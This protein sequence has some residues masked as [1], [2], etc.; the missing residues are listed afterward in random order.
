MTGI[1]VT[2]SIMSEELT[3][4]S[5]YYFTF[6][7]KLIQTVLETDDAKLLAEKNRGLK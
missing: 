6:E 2:V 5:L 1:E 7:I 3:W 4:A